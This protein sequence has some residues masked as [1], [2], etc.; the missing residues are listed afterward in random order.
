MNDNQRQTEFLRQCLLYDDSSESHTLVERIKRLQCDERCSGRGVRLMILLGTLAFAG[1]A[2]LA[3]FI[4]DFPQNMPG[5]MTRFITRAFCVV[6]L[7]SFIC[8]PAFLGLGWIYQREL[9]QVREDC[10]RRAAKLL[11]SRLA[12]PPMTRSPVA[13]QEGHRANPIA[14]GS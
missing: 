11:E 13:T 3:I 4:E 6:A 10:R 14:T 1:L 5:F 8:V 9:A 7:S 12:K 2:Y